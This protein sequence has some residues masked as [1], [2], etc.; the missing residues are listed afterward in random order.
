MTTNQQKAADLIMGGIIFNQ[1]GTMGQAVDAIAQA[2]ADAGLLAP[3]LPEPHTFPNG[4]KEWYTLDGWVNLDT[5]G[6]ITVVYDERDEDDIAAGA[7]I[8]PGEL[9][10]TRL[11]EAKVLARAFL[12]ATNHAEK[13]NKHE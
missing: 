4:E 10:F 13:E 7:E 9:V 11:S 8:D 6:T 3:D 2:L 12:A 5:D 1:S